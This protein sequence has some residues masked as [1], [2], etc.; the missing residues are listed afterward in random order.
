MGAKFPVSLLK[1]PTPFDVGPV[2]AYLIRAEPLTLIDPGPQTP[3]AENALYAGLRTLGYKIQDIKRI[4]ITHG[5]YDHS[6][7]AGRITGLSG[8]VAYIHPLEALSQAGW[9]N[10]IIRKSAIFKTGGIPTRVFDEVIAM[11]QMSDALVKTLEDFIPLGGGEVLPFE[12]FELEVLHT[13]GHAPGHLCLY[14]REEGI[15]LAG[16]MLLADITPNPF[17]ELD[18]AAQ[19]GRLKSLKLYIDSLQLLEKLAIN[20]V[21]PGH[22]RVIQDHRKRIAEIMEHHLLRSRKIA[23]ILD[24]K[25]LSPYQLAMELYQDLDA[26]NSLL[27]V[28]EVWGHLDI[29]QDEGIVERRLEEGI[30]RFQTITANS[31]ADS[32]H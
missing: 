24:S 20:E 2:N 28:S 17:L 5:H 8:A 27:G 10:M 22:G 6:G 11:A 29:L 7:L 26:F 32:I 13:P 23:G 18:Q 12:D 21:L 4:F 14:H 25:F 3:E 31:C 1:I 19:D 9:V 30:Y 15:L 16:D